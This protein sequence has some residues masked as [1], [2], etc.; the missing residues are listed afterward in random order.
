M[1]DAEPLSVYSD[2][3]RGECRKIESSQFVEATLK[4]GSANRAVSDLDGWA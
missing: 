2:S 3:S 4:V 1:L